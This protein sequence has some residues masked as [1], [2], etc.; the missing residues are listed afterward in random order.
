MRSWL[1][2]CAVGSVAHIWRNIAISL[3]DPD[4][5]GRFSMRVNGLIATFVILAAKSS[6]VYSCR[7]AFFRA[8]PL[9]AMEL[10]TWGSA[11][12]RFRKKCLDLDGST[13]SR[14][15]VGRSGKGSLIVCNA[16]RF[17][18]PKHKVEKVN[19]SNSLLPTLASNSFKVRWVP[20]FPNKVRRGHLRLTE[21][22]CSF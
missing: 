20:H 11:I 5:I 2:D 22:T 19:G 8:S 21:R 7:V 14:N 17:A 1:I 15:K 13:K 12:Q 4:G 3:I 18:S 16:A 6:E 10:Q 9:D